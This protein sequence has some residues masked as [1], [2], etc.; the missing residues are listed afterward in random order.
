V[1]T[2]ATAA[3]NVQLRAGMAPTETLVHALPA[4]EDRPSVGR[5]LVDRLR[6][7]ALLIVTLVA[8]Q[9]VTTFVS[10]PAYILPAPRE[11]LRE[12]VEKPDLVIGALVVTSTEA[13]LGFAT[14]ALLGLVFAV[15]IARSALTE[16][17]LYPY[18][19]II[20][21]TPIIALAPLLS[22]WLGHGITPIVVVA[23]LI[24]FFP[25][26]V[27]TALG[28]KS[29]DPDLVS[30]M[31][32]LNASEGQILRL[33]RL[34]NALP[35]LFSSFR[36]SAPLAVVGSL[37]GEFVGA[38]QGLGYLLLA[39][40]GRIDTSMVFLMVVLSALLGIAAF[41]AVVAVERRFIRWHPSVQLQ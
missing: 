39:A 4:V 22:I 10:V 38:G 16:Q 1:A 13:A 21:V 17:L 8:W 2:P 41:A 18:L 23:T 19:N 28:L 30:L 31:H 37:V 12:F 34:P 36:I 6:T 29:T 27:T 20:R 40:R 7:S 25:I 24:A 33:I 11:V 32:T 26:V 14:A 5:R 9:L 15:L 3:L 35:Y